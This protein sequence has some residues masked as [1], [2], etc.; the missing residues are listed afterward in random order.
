MEIWKRSPAYQILLNFLK[1]LNKAVQ[2]KK[3]SDPCEESTL[4]HSLVEMLKRIGSWVDDI[5]PTEQ[6]HRFGNKAF[7]TWHQRLVTV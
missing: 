3:L 4:I 1:Q 7:R 2:G 5:P 6:P